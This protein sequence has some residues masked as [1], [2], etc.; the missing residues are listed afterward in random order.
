MKRKIILSLFI[1]NILLGI[2]IPNNIFA[3]SSSGGYVIESYDIDM[4][5]NENNTFDITE[6]IGVNFIEDNKH[7]IFR[8]IP[9]YNTIIRQDGSKSTNKVKISNI[10]VNDSFKTSYEDEYQVLKIGSS[11][12][13]ISGR[14]TYVIKYNYDIGKD[15]LKDEDE[16][17]FNLIGDE[18]DTSISDIT[19]SI[20]MPK[21]FDESKL[22]FSSGYKFTTNDYNVNYTVIGNT[23]EGFLDEDLYSGQAFTV[24]IILPEGYFVGASSDFSF[25][26]LIE[27]G[28]S[29]IFVI[30]ALGLW[31]KYG[32][33]EIA[34]ETVEFYPPDG[35]NSVDLAF[36]YKGYSEQ[37]DIISLLIYLANK[38]YL[39]IEEFKEKKSNLKNYKIIKI[40]EY[41]GNNEDERKFFNG[42]FNSKDEVTKSDLYNEFYLTVD[43]IN[44]NV[45]RK[46][47]QEK[48]FEKASLGKRMIFIVMIAIVFFFMGGLSIIKLGNIEVIA[49]IIFILV[50]LL[51]LVY[52]NSNKWIIFISSLTFI[53]SI[54]FAKYTDIILDRIYLVKFIIESIC[55]VLLIFFLG[56]IKKRTKYGT[57][58]LGK[59][60]G[61]KNFLETV[62]KPQLEELVMENPEYFYNVLPYTYVLGISNKWIEKF[63]DITLKA[64]SW[65][66]GY[67]NFE[68]YSFYR[69]LNFTYS[70]ISR[71]M[72]S[73]PSNSNRSGGGFS[74][75]GSGGGGGGS[76]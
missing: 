37:N 22:G 4:K 40:K 25:L 49:Y 29:I 70:S 26:T 1:I 66:Y 8:K 68:S 33:D 9:L 58:M 16:F 75:G 13:K 76:W 2:L 48:I 60:K 35:M 32:K 42:L 12:K 57:E 7:G 30:V 19:F 21:E 65:Y 5:V 18:W 63:K 20:T 24:R 71:T 36:I 51:E 27:I 54:F 74:G 45:N 34:V 41:D 11:D 3:I 53:M 44:Q 64:P 62:E 39:R 72:L 59:I 10:S 23:I 52:K 14:K 50:A 15:P 61:F 73:N 38:G 17:Y 28:I 67:E 43:S 56:V 47:N 69:F 31:N 55:L 46:E 6:T